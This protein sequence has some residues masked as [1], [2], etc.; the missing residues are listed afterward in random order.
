MGVDIGSQ[1]TIRPEGPRRVGVWPGTGRAI[2]HNV[3]EE[4]LAMKRARDAAILLAVVTGLALSWGTAWAGL[5]GDVDGENVLDLR[6]ALTAMQI[7]AGINGG[8]ATADVD[9]DGQI[10]LAEATF[11]LQVVGEA[12]PGITRIQT[13][14]TDG[15]S[16]SFNGQ[17]IATSRLY[18]HGG[19]DVFDS[20]FDVIVVDSDGSN[21][22]C[23]TCV[24][25]GLV[26]CP[27]RH[28]GNPVWHPDGS[29]IVYTGEKQGN[30]AQLISSARPGSGYNCELW[31]YRTSDQVF[32][33]LTS[34]ELGST[35]EDAQGTIHP[36]FSHSG[37]KLLWAERVGG[38]GTPWPGG[39]P[40]PWGEW[41]LKVAD[42][43]TSSG[44]PKL[45]GTVSY[46]PG[47]Q[48]DFYESH[49]FSPD[50]SKI[51]FSGNLEADQPVTG[52]DI[53]ELDLRTQELKRL[54]HTPGDWDE[55]A[56]YSPDGRKIAWM[57]SA[58]MVVD[59]PPLL[60]GREW[61][62]YIKTEL[63][64]MDSDGSNKVR[65][66]AYNE[67]EPDGRHCVVSDSEWDPNGTDIYALVM[68]L[69]DGDVIE[70]AVKRIVR[71]TLSY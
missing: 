51:L 57:S 47:S 42:F 28:N 39:L 7:L 12:R 41:V 61:R 55:H 50:D 46:Q 49:G 32:T 40:G 26:N 13:V 36:Q 31:A 60:I 5:R 38:Q 22:R 59:W 25:D 24:C 10:G 20:Y 14:L 33:R 53:Y 15:K 17:R 44:A 19:G 63:W 30:P 8:D 6:D 69:D 56:H 68:C 64:L 16:V 3:P 23:V 67:T 27:R 11:V 71:I 34:L 35:S 65:L 48:H 66:T 4:T 58:G 18:D 52:L 45:L 70:N 54:T 9:A 2:A 37:G 1:A 29:Y 21:E 62:P 43:D